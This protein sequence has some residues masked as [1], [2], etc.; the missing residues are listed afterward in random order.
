M[1][2]SMRGCHELVTHSQVTHLSNDVYCVP[3]DSLTLLSAQQV[4]YTFA[5]D[6]DLANAHP[7]WNFAED[8]S[9]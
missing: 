6:E 4:E 5:T 8:R 3:W 2:D 7:I 1:D 9:R